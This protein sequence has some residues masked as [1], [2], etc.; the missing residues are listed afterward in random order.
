M[1]ILDSKTKENKKETEYANNNNNNN[2]KKRN[3]LNLQNCVSLCV[4]REGGNENYE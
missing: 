1:R 2:N 4:C 3:K